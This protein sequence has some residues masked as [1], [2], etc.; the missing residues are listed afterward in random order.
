LS[1]IRNNNL[2]P[3]SA[4]ISPILSLNPKPPLKQA[5]T[6][7]QLGLIPAEQFNNAT[8]AIL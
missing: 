2:Y 5:Q 3:A 6:L 4:H 1:D 7:E 8:I